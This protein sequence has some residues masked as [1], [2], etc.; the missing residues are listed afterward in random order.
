[1]NGKFAV[2]IY[3][4]GAINLRPKDSTF[5][6]FNDH[7]LAVLGLLE[8]CFDYPSEKFIMNIEIFRF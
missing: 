7:M 2:G 1:M 8:G 4:L 3:T 5:Y 6:G